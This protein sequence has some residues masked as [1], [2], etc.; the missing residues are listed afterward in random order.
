MEDAAIVAVVP[1]GLA[2]QNIDVVA[3]KAG[4]MP[5]IVATDGVADDKAPEP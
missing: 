4:E 1:S 5:E 2:V 3:V